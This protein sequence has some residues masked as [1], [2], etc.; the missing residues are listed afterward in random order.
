MCLLGGSA[1]VMSQESE[2]S[3]AWGPD[4]GTSIPEL[5]VKDVEGE[6]KKLEDL[7]GAKGTLFVLVRSTVW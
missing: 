3:N 4:V 6:D 2:Y 5:H 7:A 1:S